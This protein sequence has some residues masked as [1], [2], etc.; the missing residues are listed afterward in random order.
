MAHRVDVVCSNHRQRDVRH[1]LNLPLFI[2]RIHMFRQAKRHLVPVKRTLITASFLLLGMQLLPTAAQ[3]QATPEISSSLKKMLGALPLADVKDQ[4]HGMVGA[5]KK[6]SCGGG[7]T[8]CYATQAGPIQL[9]FFTSKQA[10]QTFLLVIDKKMA[11]PKLLKD[12]VHRVFGGGETSLDTPIISIST[13]DFDLET[14]KM[15]P[16]L[17]KVVR[18]SYFNVQ[19]LS[20]ASG[21]QLAARANV[22]GPIKTAMESLGVKASQLTLRAAVV[23]PIPT[24]LV[25]GAG[26]GAGMAGAMKDGDTFKKAGADALSP[27]AFVEL[28]FAPNSV[29]HLISPPMDL[30]DATFFIN[31]S[32]TFGYK[33]N[34]AFRGVKATKTL[35]HFQTPLTPAGVM[36]FADFQFMMATPSSFT[37]EDSANLMFDM[38][39][40]D[41]RL[42]KY[43]GGFI[44]NIESI[45][46]PILA[47][48]KALSVFKL[49]NPVPPA[50]YK[51]ADPNKPFP[52]DPKYFNVALAGP[53]ADGGPLIR[54]AGETTV[55]GQ[56][57]GLLDATADVNG[58]RGK[59]LSDLSLKLGPLGKVTLQKMLAEATVDQKTQQVRLKGNY[60]GQT[61]EVTLAGSTLSIDVPANCVNPFEIKA[62]VAFD[63]NTNI[64]D[65]FEAHGGA[66]VDPSKIGGCVGKQLE[67][68]LN[69][70]A[71]EYKSLGGYSANDA[72]KALKKIS[73]DAEAAA[74]KA[75]KEAEAAANK[76]AKEAK[77]R[78]RDLANKSTSSAKKV[79]DDVGNSVSRLFGK[80]KNKD[81]DEDDIFDPSV[82]DWEYYYDTRG[83]AWGDRDLF[84]HWKNYGFKNGE[85]GSNE[86]LMSDY[87]KRY[88]DLHGADK[89]VL[90]HWLKDGINQGRQ[91]S[92]TF[93]IQA[94]Q[95]RYPDLRG[96]SYR[97]VYNH[98]M[99]HG[100][101]QEHRNG[102]P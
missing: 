93:S 77:D 102:R 101:D 13:A 59:V 27:E 99:E 58:F 11:L 24:D 5:L 21:V 100:R 76:A 97:D 72:N 73:D 32:L 33:G 55:L 34:A 74:N 26:A 25:G 98:W 52:T 48:A 53:F 57:M 39:T 65:V 20:F 30:T 36:D 94:Y 88:S 80:K 1:L 61:V 2:S 3:A 90:N 46:K 45:K 86:F 16:D 44:R 9:Y 43:G 15:P 41:P 12:D 40:S 66:N 38:A 8:G 50:E 70:I 28:Q 62:N 81:N 63:A 87:R 17:Q 19:S 6:T 78:A 14:V 47:T 92:P 54:F 7:L 29:L 84:E 91:A 68:A 69:K 75:A 31:N 85:Q 51:F 79:F 71:N 96:W 42:A 64:A 22:G 67:A 37:L 10:Q 95:R 35:L 56:R 49:K 82:F 4:V 18:D 60:G 89:D 23:M 83:A